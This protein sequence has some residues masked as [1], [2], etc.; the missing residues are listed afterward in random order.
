MIEMAN[1]DPVSVRRTSVRLGCRTDA[2]M[3]FEKNMNP[4]LTMVSFALMM[5]MIKQYKVL[6]GEP[7]FAGM[8][9]WMDDVTTSLMSSGRYIDFDPVR[10]H[11]IIYGIAIE[12]QSP[13]SKGDVTE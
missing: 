11:Q 8:T 4:C 3:R 7:V 5:D 10:C 12:E 2:V 13:L 9:Y 1:F 6:I